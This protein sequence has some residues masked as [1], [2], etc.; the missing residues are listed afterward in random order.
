M[1]NMMEERKK[2]IADGLAAAEQG[3]RE[4]ELAQ[5]KS[6]EALMEA[7]ATAAKI[8][9]QANQRAGGIVEDAKDRARDE[10]AR[11]VA[12]AEA[13]IEQERHRARQALLQEVSGL[14]IAGAERILQNQV[15]ASQNT[16]LVDE[17]IG[18]V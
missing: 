13:E 14:A 3:H 9:E 17:L 4:L 10:G 16:K 12:L 6:Q 2:K 5:I 8:I 15:D 1:V 18:E 7:K 11:L